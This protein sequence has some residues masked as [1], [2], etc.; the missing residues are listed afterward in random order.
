MV[1]LRKTV[2]HVLHIEQVQ[3]NLTQR[4]LERLRPD[5]EALINVTVEHIRSECQALLDRALQQLRDERQGMADQLRAEYTVMPR[6]Q[7][8]Q[9]LDYQANTYPVKFDAPLSVAGVELPVPAPNDRM[10]YAPN[11]AADYLRWGALDHDLILGHIKKHS[12]GFQNRTILDFGCSS[13]RVLRHF[14]AER[15][16]HDWQLIG[17]DIQARPIEWMRHYFPP[18]FQ[19]AACSTMPHLPFADSS[20]DFIYGISVFTHIK[21]L[22]DMWLLE[23]KRVLKPG[24]LLMQTIHAEPAWKFYHEQ[25]NEEWVKSGHSAEM[26]TKPEMDVDFL[27]YGDVSC[28]QVFWKE[29]VARRFWGRYL[30]V[31]EVTPPPARSFQ[32]WMICRK[33]A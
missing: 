6:F 33:P 19:V 18:Y 14:D 12:S 25:R 15:R 3:Q 11:D 21:Y 26:L 8:H 29:S 20:I 17:V 23:L 13:G 27:Y 22:W 1:N 9:P 32:N 30:E 28:S 2:K 16:E 31:L 7:F 10:G 4:V 24:G 5:C